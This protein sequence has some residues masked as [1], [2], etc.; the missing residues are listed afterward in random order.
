MIEIFFIWHLKR[1]LHRTLVPMGR[2]H[3][4]PARS[5]CI[6]R[7]MRVSLPLGRQC[8]TPRRLL[9]LQ[10]GAALAMAR[11]DHGGH[12]HCPCPRTFVYLPGRPFFS[13]HPILSRNL[14]QNW[15]LDV[16]WWNLDRYCRLELNN[17]NFSPPPITICHVSIIWVS[18]NF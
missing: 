16:D 18:A 8:S 4:H 10:E 15:V 12:R 9:Q 17:Y 11:P 6:L 13:G 14:H 1:H 3:F 5:I 2:R 7:T